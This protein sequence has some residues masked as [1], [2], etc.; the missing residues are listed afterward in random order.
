MSN[1]PIKAERIFSKMKTFWDDHMFLLFKSAAENHL[2]KQSCIKHADGTYVCT[3]SF[4][5]FS[6][7]K[8]YQKKVR[9]LTV[10]LSMAII[11][12]VASFLLGHVV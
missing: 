5:S 1:I 3:M 4:Q 12:A 2:R 6:A 10:S 7:L 11:M 9:R 8:R